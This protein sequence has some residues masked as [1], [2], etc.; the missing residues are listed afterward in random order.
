MDR[1]EVLPNNIEMRKALFTGKMRLADVIQSN[2]NLIPTLSRLNIPFGFGNKRVSEVCEQH[3]LSTGFFLLI[4]NVYTFKEYNP[5]AEQITPAD[6]A[7]TVRYLKASH[8]YYKENRLPHIGGHLEKIVKC[9]EPKLARALR[10][11]FTEYCEE[12]EEHFAYEES[13]V[14]PY[15]EALATGNTLEPATFDKLASRHSDI[16]EKLDDLTQIIW[17]Y[18]PETVIPEEAVSIVFDILQLSE[19][20]RKHS[21]I[22]DKIVVRFAM[23]SNET[24]K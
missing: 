5:S 18:L 20:I 17:K 15:V 14:F 10:K 3:G 8:R 1:K 12:L 22:E 6:I 21:L 24:L 13:T 16:D 9:V 11:F 4:A 2:P 7:A 23:L 19:D